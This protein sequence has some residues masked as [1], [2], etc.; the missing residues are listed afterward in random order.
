MG[1]VALS[2]VRTLAG[3][4]LLGINE[5]AYEVSAEAIE[6]DRQLINLSKQEE[7]NL[8]KLSWLE[9]RKRQDQFL[10]SVTLEGKK[11]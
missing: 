11:K 7:E 4:K 6:L 2:R 5:T 3:I 1:Y 8:K 9:K 10:E